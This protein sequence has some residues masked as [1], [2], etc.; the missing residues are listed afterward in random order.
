MASFERF[1]RCAK[2]F[3]D[4]V[5]AHRMIKE[6]D[7][8]SWLNQLANL[9]QNALELDFPASYP[10]TNHIDID[11]QLSS[12]S[13][14]VYW[15]VFTPLILDEPVAGSLAD[16]IHDIYIEIKRGLI[17]TQTNTDAALWEWKWGFDNHIVQ[18][19]NCINC[20]IAPMIV[21]SPFPFP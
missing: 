10:D 1:Y 2:I 20:V 16:D 6:S 14:D 18:S 3:C 17:L 7:Y 4:F 12:D 15:E 9:Y 11:I 8:P 19:S 21:K 5:D 13:S